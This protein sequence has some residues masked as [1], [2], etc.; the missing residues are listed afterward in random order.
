MGTIVLVCPSKLYVLTPLRTQKTHTVRSDQGGN[1]AREGAGMLDV[2]GYTRIS[3]TGQIGDGRDGRQGVIR[4]REDVY[5]LAE[6]K[7]VNV[8]HVYEDNDLS[9]YKRNVSRRGFEEMTADL[10]S[11]AISGILA[12]NIDRIA[13]Q[14]RDLER[15]ID[16]YEQARRPMIFATTA[17]DYDLTTPDGRFEA[18]IHVNIA[19]KFSADAARRVARQKLAEATEGKPHKGQRAF[20]WKDAEH[21]DETEAEILRKARKDIVNGKLVASVHR[22][23]AE[24][25]VRTPQTPSGKTISY[26]SVTYVLRNPRLCGYRAYI[27]RCTATGPGAWTPSSTSSSAWTAPRSSGRGRPSSPRTSGKNWWTFSTLARKRARAAR[28]AARS[29]SDY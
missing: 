16:I 21:V 23:W 17:G 19:N 22:E 2:G 25:M 26:S 5:N 18:R 7:R 10:A 11:A 4:Q 13:R 3:D 1:G 20:G 12:Y 27:P 29:Q 24:A 15:L 14:P 8:R 28:S 6:L 9:A